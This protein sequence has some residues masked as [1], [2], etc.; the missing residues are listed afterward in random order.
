MPYPL[1]GFL[2]NDLCS[3]TNKTAKIN[4]L[5]WCKSDLLRGFPRKGGMKRCGAMASTTF[6][7]RCIYLIAINQ[8]NIQSEASNWVGMTC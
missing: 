7:K 4:A 6:E 3:I 5:S 1:N 8:K 2:K